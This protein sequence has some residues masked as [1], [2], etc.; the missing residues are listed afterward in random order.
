LEP[1]LAQAAVVAGGLAAAPVG[2][3]DDE[4]AATLGALLQGPLEGGLALLGGHISHD[5]GHRCSSQ[6]IS[7]AHPPD[8]PAF[9]TDATPGEPV[10]CDAGPVSAAGFS[11]AARGAA[12]NRPDRSR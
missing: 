10:L 11:A 2:V 6:M 5:D 8:G 4:S 1:L 3:D 7:T 12:A 9:V